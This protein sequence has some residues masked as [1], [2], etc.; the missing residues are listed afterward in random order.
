MEGKVKVKLVTQEISVLNEDDVELL[1]D[2]I[3]LIVEEG[4]EGNIVEGNFD[5]RK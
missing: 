2:F 5:R 1:T 4:F 3:T